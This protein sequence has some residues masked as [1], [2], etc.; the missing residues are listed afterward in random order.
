VLSVRRRCT[1]GP[2]LF[3]PLPSDPTPYRVALVSAGLVRGRRRGQ[4]VPGCRRISSCR[5]QRR[6]WRRRPVYG[7]TRCAILTGAASRNRLRYCLVHAP[8]GHQRTTSGTRCCP[9]PAARRH[10]RRGRSARHSADAR[11]DA[12]DNTRSLARPPNTEL[13]SRQQVKGPAIPEHDPYEGRGTPPPRGT[14]PAFVGLRLCGPKTNA[15][16]PLL[17]RYGHRGQ[18]AGQGYLPS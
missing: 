15:P 11:F 16:M 9:L 3:G 6:R 14:H 1:T 12:G 10:R 5:I 4:R 7:S 13:R 8:A 18:A 17:P 2:A